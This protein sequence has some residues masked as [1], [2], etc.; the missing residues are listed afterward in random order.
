MPLIFMM[1]SVTVS[2]AAVTQVWVSPQTTGLPTCTSA[3]QDQC[4]EADNPGNPLVGPTREAPRGSDAASQA[5]AK[6]FIRATS[7]VRKRI[8]QV[9]SMPPRIEASSPEPSLGVAFT[10]TP[11]G[12]QVIAIMPGS[13]AA[14]VGLKAGSMVTSVNGDSLASMSAAAA[15]TLLRTR[16]NLITYGMADGGSVTLARPSY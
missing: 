14:A 1:L 12:A 9:T 2:S 4:V 10:I 16:A 5:A 15:S 13:P 6:A 8:P 3:D 11:A 7:P